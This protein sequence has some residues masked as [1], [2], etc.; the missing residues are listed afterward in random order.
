MANAVHPDGASDGAYYR[1]A[2]I[3]R[4]FDNTPVSITTVCQEDYFD[5]TIYL[6]VLRS[7]NIV[8]AVRGGCLL[9][10]LPSSV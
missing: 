7:L 2:V 8:D 4:P 5:W 1:E 6:M 9:R 3:M 10:Y